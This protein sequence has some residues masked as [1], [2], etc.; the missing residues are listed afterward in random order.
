MLIS[1][2]NSPCKFLFDFNSHCPACGIGFY[3]RTF[4]AND[5]Q[6]GGAMLKGTVAYIV[7]RGG[8]GDFR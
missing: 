7:D 1:V 8:N 4:L 3:V 2:Q 6:R 5:S